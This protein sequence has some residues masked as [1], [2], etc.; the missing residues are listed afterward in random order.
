MSFL[1]VTW[2]FIILALLT[3]YAVLDGF[4]LGAGIL[5]L[6]AGREDD[7]RA[8]YAAIGPFW[9]GNEVWL[10]TGGGAIFA[11]FPHV[12]AT[13][14]SGF[15]LAFMLLL[16]A[17]IFRAAAIEFR[18]KHDSAAWHKLWDVSFGLGSLLAALLFG[19]AIGNIL[20]GISLNAG[21]DY[22][23]TFLELLNPYALTFGLLSVL[24]F[25]VHG[26][27]FIK[28]RASGDIS[29]LSTYFAKYAAYSYLII[30]LEVLLL[31]Y[32][33]QKHL[34]VNFA[35][36]PQLWALPVLS[37]IMIVKTARFGS[38]VSSTIA[39][40]SNF[41]MIG[42]A[43]FPMIVPARNGE[44]FSLTL[45]NSSSSPLTLTVMIII[46]IIGMPLVIGY[47]IWSYTLFGKQPRAKQTQGRL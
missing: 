46:A 13:V 32:I 42:A 25:A 34:F 33:W 47:T 6:F 15:Y 35:T 45:M 9:D 31:S 41:G 7:K 16:A 20:R 22:A 36:H 39:I 2:Y 1:Q 18:N 38:F 27:L 24:M 21:M 23:G 28:N 26:A 14:F 43:L 44:E 10:L 40:I 17:L 37:I 19:V 5:S 12:Y 4:D 11:A 29:L 8:I 30:F 3:V